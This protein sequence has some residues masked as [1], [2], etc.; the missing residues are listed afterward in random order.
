MFEDESEQ[1][2]QD[3]AFDRTSTATGG[4]LRNAGVPV[5]FSIEDILSRSWEILRSDSFRTIGTIWSGI[6]LGFVPLILVAAISA[7]PKNQGRPPGPGAQILGLIAVG[8]STLIFAGILLYV[9]N[10]VS[11]RIARFGDLF[12]CRKFAWSILLSYILMGL[13]A[14]GSQV[15]FIFITLLLGE[16]IGD[17][18]LL[19]GFFV[20]VPVFTFVSLSLSQVP[21]LIVDRDTTPLNSLKLSWALMR[22]HRLEFLFLTFL[23]GC[24]NLLGLLAF[25]FGILIAFPFNMICLAVFYMAV[26]GQPVADPYGWSSR[27]MKTPHLP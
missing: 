22:G 7:D 9:T 21:F 4:I 20:G 8:L 6:F 12:R 16:I 1:P 27:S 5:S 2:Y 13:A 19:I 15:L 23:C 18:A 24:I 25:G 11:G 3:R 14:L 17:L 26:T 10:L